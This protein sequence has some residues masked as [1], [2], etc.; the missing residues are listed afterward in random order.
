[1][2]GAVRFPAVTRRDLRE[3]TVDSLREKL[4]R[5]LDVDRGRLFLTHGATEGNALV[6]FYVARETRRKRGAVGRYRVWWPEYPPLWES[7]EAAGLR[8][9]SGSG[10]VDLAVAS[11]PRNPEGIRWTVP[12]LEERTHR[13]VSLLVD[14]TFREFTI[15]PSVAHLD[16]H[17]WWATGTFTKA[18]GGDRLRVGWIVAPSGEVER[19]RRWHELLTDGIPTASLAGAWRC[20]SE[21]DR[22]LREVHRR[23]ERNREI[24]GRFRPDAASIAAP[25]YLDR[26]EGVDSRRLAR[27]ALRSSILV[28][29]G[30]YFG[31]S[32]GLRICLTRPQFST[33]FAAYLRFREPRHRGVPPESPSGAQTALRRP[34]LAGR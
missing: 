11:N 22:I 12:K 34:S 19:F 10:P 21:C 33:D 7:A 23:F 13:A 9:Q 2:A 1:M 8:I 3:A 28:A 25:V 26:V 5:H 4:A 16:R 18:Y 17:G 27:K 31:A 24:L 29:P 15:V 6:T 20:L 32:D 14:E 30:A